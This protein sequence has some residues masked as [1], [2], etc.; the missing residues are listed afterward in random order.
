[1][2][3]RVPI[4]YEGLITPSENTIF[5]FGSNPYGIH[6][7][8]S[9][10]VAVKSFGAVYG[11]GEGLQ[12]QA[13]ALPTKDISVLKNN[14]LRSISPEQITENIKKMY[15]VA[16]SNPHLLFKV[17]YT[18]KPT[19]YTL[20]GYNGG[21]MIAMFKAAGEIPDNVIFSKVWVDEWNNF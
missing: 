4:Y 7:A 2:E 14:G 1:M 6:G 11:C 19:E 3:K 13:Y 16:K 10:A 5:V 18:N 20:N 15:E 9:A 17:A 12:G 8:G 21:E